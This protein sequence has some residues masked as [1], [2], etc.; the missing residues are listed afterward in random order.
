MMIN[1]GT[2]L[3]ITMLNWI[4]ISRI[5]LIKNR[6]KKTLKMFTTHVVDLCSSAKTQIRSI[7]LIN[8]RAPIPTDLNI[9][10]LLLFLM[11]NLMT[12]NILKSAYARSVKNVVSTGGSFIRFELG[13]LSGSHWSEWMPGW[14]KP[15]RMHQLGTEKIGSVDSRK[16][17]IHFK[18]SNCFLSLRHLLVF[19]TRYFMASSLSSTPALSIFVVS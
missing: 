15:A 13:Y 5:A 4:H 6:I 14:F 11:N 8:I 19:S 7:A 3:I 2:D 16:S 1:T 17:D 12:M 18:G 9:A 10:L